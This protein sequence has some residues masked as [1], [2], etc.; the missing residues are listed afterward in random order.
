MK[1]LS[2][3]TVFIVVAISLLAG[4]AWQVTRIGG[5]GALG[6]SPGA[7]RYGKVKRGDLMQKVTVSGQ[8]HPFRRTIFVAP[9]TGYI[10]KIYVSVGQAIK[11][12]DPVISVVSSLAS[13][14]HVFPIRAPFSGVVVDVPKSE[15]E[16]VSEKDSKDFMVR[17]DDLSKF[18]VVAKAPELDASR[19]V[20][21]MEV[22]V[23]I[24]A[25]K[26]NGLKGIVRGVDLAAQEA[27]GWRQQ[28]ATFEVR[29]EILK[30]PKLIRSGQSAILDIVTSKYSDVL[31]LESEFINQEG[32]K[33]FVITRRGE[34]KPIEVGRQS[35]T[36]MEVKGL[37]EGDEVE[38]IDFMKLLESGA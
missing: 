2:K 23:R 21:G 35:D 16:F 37:N 7:K 3:R 4:V 33:Y 18:Y 24:S 25:L 32:N 17:V 30:P 26:D 20:I 8:I 6:S 14:E 11:A 1:L 13:P 27:D 34:R 15:G 12:G 10:R 19:I 38:Q 29:V 31:Y 28:Q 5:R 22:D 36:A 9:Y